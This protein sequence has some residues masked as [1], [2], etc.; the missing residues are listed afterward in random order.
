MRSWHGR[1][2]IVMT[3][4]LLAVPGPAAAAGNDQQPARIDARHAATL[5]VFGGGSSGSAG[6]GGALGWAIGWQPMA[7]MAIEGSG[8]WTAEPAISGFVGLIGPRFD[9]STPRLPTPF[10]SFEVGVYRASVDAADNPPA[11]YADRMIDGATHRSFDD[12]VMAPGGGVDFRIRKHMTL[13]PQVRVLLVRSDTSTRPMAMFGAHV[14]YVFG[15]AS[16]GN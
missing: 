6:T 5:S 15:A 3:C 4:A 1:I 13:R 2:G 10:V 9:L 11:F 12:F 8:S 16:G 14:S 7:R